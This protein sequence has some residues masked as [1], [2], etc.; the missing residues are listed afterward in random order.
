MAT[1]RRAWLFVAIVAALATLAV[2]YL[3]W[4][5]RRSA[6]SLESPRTASVSGAPA[7]VL[8]P[9]GRP[10]FLF[11][12]TKQ[13]DAYGA[14]AFTDVDRREQPTPIRKLVCRRVHMAGGR[15]VCLAPR[16][17]TTFYARLFDDRFEV[18][19]ELKLNGVPSRVQVAPD[20]R[21]AAVTVFVTGHSYQDADF[22]TQTSIVD[23]TSGHWLIENLETFTVRRNGAVRMSADFNF[24]GVTF[25][26]DGRSFY[27]TLSTRGEMLL[28]R[29]SVDTRTVDVV[30]TNVECP[31]ISPDNT[32]VAFKQ[33][34]KAVGA[35]S[36]E[37]WVLDLGTRKRHRLPEE[38]SI[39]DQLQWLDD[40][41][42]LYARASER[43]PASTDLWMAAADG[44]GAPTRYLDDAYSGTLV[45]PQAVHT[46][47][48]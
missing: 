3:A 14:L 10:I 15:G 27:A 41:H 2:A 44:T 1:V 42:V 40:R 6:D 36:W 13:T 19:G 48:E 31:S 4:A 35:A 17:G 12:W 29:G 34:S 37:I 22:S 46:G 32:K 25:L 8:P 26:R 11:R 23:L 5:V 47:M 9:P 45:T 33:R 43:D 30:D 20:G 28:V 39:D 24:W 16:G 21:L 18:S 7:A 38:H